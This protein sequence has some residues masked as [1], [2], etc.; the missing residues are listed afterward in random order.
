MIL[1][2]IN[3][4]ELNSSEI[5]KDIE[6]VKFALKNQILVNLQ[7]KTVVFGEYDSSV[8]NRSSDGKCEMKK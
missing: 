3:Y 2:R 6:K 8:T 7:Y 1:N 4:D 5:K